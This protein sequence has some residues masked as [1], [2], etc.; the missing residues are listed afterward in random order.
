MEM[1][2]LKPKAMM[3]AVSVYPSPTGIFCTDTCVSVCCVR[4][5]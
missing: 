2:G 1:K 4:P 5:P 3:L